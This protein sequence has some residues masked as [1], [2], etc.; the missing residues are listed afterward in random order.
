[1]TFDQKIIGNDFINE[2]LNKA[3]NS[4][5]FGWNGTLVKHFTS[6]AE[7]LHQAYEAAISWHFLVLS[8]YFLG[9]VHQFLV[10]GLEFLVKM[11]RYTTGLT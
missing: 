6:A 1:M 9:M 8:C 4:L 7:I 5:L 11:P 2:R 10:K 3:Y